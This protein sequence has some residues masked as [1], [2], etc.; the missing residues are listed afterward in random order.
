MTGQ[1]EVQD[2]QVAAVGESQGADPVGCLGD[3]VPGRT[4]VVGD[5]TAHGRIVV[6]EQDVSHGLRV[7][8]LI[9]M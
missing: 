2:H 4:Q 9:R 1:H 6:D 7:G 5:H 3:A 8:L